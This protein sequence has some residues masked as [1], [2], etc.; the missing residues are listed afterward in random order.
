MPAAD[1][2]D[3]APDAAPSR[4]IVTI[5][6]GPQNQINVPF[7]LFTDAPGAIVAGNEITGVTQAG[8]WTVVATIENFPG[9][10]PGVLVSDR[11]TFTVLP[12]VGASIVLG[13][14]PGVVEAGTAATLTARLDDAFG[15]EVTGLAITLGSS[16][17][18]AVFTGN[19]VRHDLTGNKVLTA[20][21]DLDG[22]TVVDLTQSVDLD[23]VAAAPATIVLATSAADVDGAT[24]GTQ[25]LP[26][27]LI[28]LSWTVTDGFGNAIVTAV[29]VATGASGLMQRTGPSGAELSGLL[30][31]GSV[32][33]L[34]TVTGSGVADAL[35][36][37][38]V[39]GATDRVRMSLSASSVVAGD[40]VV[41][42]SS[43]QDAWG[44]T[45]TG[46]SVLLS[47]DSPAV[48][49]IIDQ[50][51]GTVTIEAAGSWNITATSVADGSIS[52][53]AAVS[54][55]AGP[56]ALID[57]QLS[58]NAVT[59]GT[60][61]TYTVAT[62]DAFNNPSAASVRVV[63]D[64]PFA[65]I[66]AGQITGLFLTGAFTV[67]AEAL[68]TGVSD[69][70]AL[71]VT[72]GP[73][74][75]IDLVLERSFQ[76]L[77]VAVGY[78]VTVQDVFG[79]DVPALPVMSSSDPLAVIN[80]GTGTI[81]FG[82]EGIQT[83]TAT[84]SLAL[85]DTESI[86]TFVL[87]DTTPPTIAIT[88]PASGTVV[89][90][91][92]QIIITLDVDDDTALFDLRVQAFGVVQGSES[93]LFPPATPLPTTL[94]FPVDIPLGSAFGALTITAAVVDTSG[95]AA[96][97]TPVQMRVDPVGGVTV[98]GG[99]ATLVAGGPGSG[100]SS[101]LGITTDGV[102]GLYVANSGDST[103]QLVDS[104][105]GAVSQYGVSLAEAPNDAA[106]DPGTLELFISLGDRIVLMDG[107]GA[108]ADPWSATFGGFA[109]RGLF[110]LP[111]VG[112]ITADFG[113]DLVVLFDPL[114]APLAPPVG[115][116]I[117]GGALDRP[118]GVALNTVGATTAIQATNLGSNEIL[119][120]DTIFPFP[121]RSLA[122]GPPIARPFEI[123]SLTNGDLLVA[124]QGNGSLVRI[125]TSVCV[126]PGTPCNT[127]TVAS[128]FAAPVGLVLDAAG[129]RV[130]VTDLAW[131]AVVE[132]TGAF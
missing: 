52:A 116:G 65:T 30:E 37:D 115:F 6:D 130:W 112:L 85:S 113:N 93:F 11:A 33:V 17:A 42:T 107:T 74:S 73:A 99:T 28:P 47:A 60:A 121:S 95:N 82:T 90:P 96:V 111:G 35:S 49:T 41:V 54:V 53:T 119:E 51:A 36:L 72:T 26:D 7:R 38:V 12:D 20:G 18:A 24:A 68:D 61:V 1:A 128:G 45:V 110:L 129:T 9:A 105:T 50:A 124:S 56:T 14:S 102:G 29:D 86:Q 77:G 103:I 4:P 109:P 27:T 8:T 55:V 132:V 97:A 92:D 63:S 66:A 44:N 13:V 16:D 76:P 106:M 79:N 75:S 125:D 83:V 100:L 59:P 25:V 34:A 126:A 46:D 40:A 15:N 21:V 88:A 87:P 58:N 62:T 114:A 32:T 108:V 81:V 80:A 69:T 101:P 98:A 2:I 120:E 64:A 89:A 127:T 39:A 122:A 3:V 131:D 57:L 5:V 123:I 19:D 67:F 10:A 84:L 94:N 48:Q 71:A 22:D 104:A 43:I 31:A 78:T 118:W 23:V 70:E 91:G 117:M